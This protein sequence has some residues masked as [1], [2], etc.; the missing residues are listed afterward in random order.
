MSDFEFVA[1]QLPVEAF[2]FSTY[3]AM[4]LSKRQAK[5][6]AAR[7]QAERVFISSGYQ[8]NINPTA[9]PD[10]RTAGMWLSCKRRDKAVIDDRQALGHVLRALAPGFH[11]YELFPRAQRT[12]DTAN[13][14]HIWAYSGSCPF[15]S[16]SAGAF[17][18]LDER[19]EVA[20]LDVPDIGADIP[21]KLLRI[22]GKDGGL[23]QDWRVLQERKADALGDFEAVM[24][25]T[26]ENQTNPW[27]GCLIVLASQDAGFPFG[28]SHGLQMSSEQAARLNAQQRDF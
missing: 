2:K 22:S 8:V 27:Q 9:S 3:M 5:Q 24:L 23:E 15:L 7:M 28:F 11:G 4:G 6:A 1:A 26:P 18:R 21:V 17:S 14:Y 10:P 25:H 16:A 20:E 12:V 19:T 13:Q